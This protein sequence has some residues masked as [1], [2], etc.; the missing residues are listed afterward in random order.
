MAAAI[1]TLFLLLSDRPQLTS[2]QN[3]LRLKISGGLQDGPAPGSVFL[4]VE[5]IPIRVPDL[6]H[7]FREAAQD[8]RITG[9]F[10]HMDNP[11]LS[12]AS[13]QEIRAGLVELEKSGKTCTTWSKS[14]DTIS[15][16]LASACSKIVLHP[17]G[18]P[19]VVG[20]QLQTQHFRGLWDK[21][22]LNA[23]IYRIGQYKSAPES[24]LQDEPSEPSKFQMTALLNSLHGQFLR[25]TSESRSI[26]PGA[27]ES[28]LNDPPTD[29][30][31]ALSRGLVDETAYLADLERSLGGE[32]ERLRPFFESLKKR[33]SQPKKAVAILHLQGTI[34]DGISQVPFGGSTMA[35]D[36][37]LVGELESLTE[38]SDVAA[39]VLRVNSPGGSAIASDSIWQ[40][41][42]NANRAKPVVVSMGNYAASGG[43]Y[44]SMPASHIVAQP[45]TLTGSIGI[46]GGKIDMSGLFDKA[47]THVWT[48][49][50]TP[51]AGMNDPSSPYTDAQKSKLMER[52]QGFYTSFIT[53]AAQGRSMSVEELHER[54]QGR[55]WTGEDALE[56]GLVDSLGGLED[57]IRKAEELAQLDD[58]LGRWVLPE[59]QT[60]WDMIWSPPEVDPDVLAQIVGKVI[61]ESLAKTTTEALI[62]AE[63]LQ[64]E[65]AL[66][67]VPHRISVQ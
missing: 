29:A 38:N 56:Q 17:E 13:A 57:A 65:G 39:I 62:L 41:V 7:T 49:S 16:Y 66:A 5:E 54:A 44:V 63:L 19:Q 25:D 47:G 10:L 45:A 14:Y 6:A 30:Q 28:L 23:E 9:L 34:V 42:A 12:M 11:V 1:A 4:S 59:D 60:L 55:V 43:Y 50:R 36:R 8:E 2:D 37:S 48:T 33:W 20:F 15:W 46:F 51:F 31:S 18:V 32:F 27:V 24:Y 26:S 21:L 40:A 22:G 67:L 53:K 35:G 61:P 64:T 58:E 52:L 3:I